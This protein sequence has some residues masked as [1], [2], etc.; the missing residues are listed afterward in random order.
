MYEMRGY[1]YHRGEQPVDVENK[2]VCFSVDKWRQDK[3]WYYSQIL[4]RP[5]SS[6]ILESGRIYPVLKM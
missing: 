5:V 1:C 6:S 3:I 2:W 4:S